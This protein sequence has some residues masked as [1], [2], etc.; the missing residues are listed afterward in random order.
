VR[1]NIIFILICLPFLA[2]VCESSKEDTVVGSNKDV[3]ISGLTFTIDRSYVSGL[4]MYANGTVRNEG[5][6]KVTS[7]WFVEGQFYTDSTY[8]LKLGGDN[9]QISVPLDHGQGTIWNLSFY[10]N[11]GT[12]QIYPEFKIGN[13]RGIYKNQ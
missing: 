7:P 11:Q 8:S 6:A 4:T 1:I 5:S 9:V 10:L 3:E 2:F 12:T 13:L